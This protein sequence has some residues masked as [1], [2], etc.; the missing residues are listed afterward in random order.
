MKIAEESAVAAK[1][2]IMEAQPKFI[3]SAL[4]PPTISAGTARVVDQTSKIIQGMNTV[5][6]VM[7]N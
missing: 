2:T 1:A 4:K 5:A 6:A 3:S 7:E